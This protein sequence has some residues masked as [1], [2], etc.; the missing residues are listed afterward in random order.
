[1]KGLDTNVLLTWLL[2][3]DS[4]VLDPDDMYRIN[5]VVVA[6]LVWVLDRSLRKSR[7]EIAEVVASLLA[8][9]GLHFQGREAVVAALEDYRH[10][11]ADFADYLIARDNLE[12]GCEATL[13]FDQ[14]AARHSAFHLVG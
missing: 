12:A 8:S 9:V 10:G 5:F 11:P 13:T 14:R 6:E 4:D 7:T 2:D 3:A 1:M